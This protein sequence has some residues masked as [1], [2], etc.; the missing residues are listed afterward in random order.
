MSQPEQDH[1]FSPGEHTLSRT[2]RPIPGYTLNGDALYDRDR[3]HSAPWRLK[4]WDFYQIA[5][6]TL[7]LQLVIGHVSYA[8][9]CN[10]ALFNHLTGE[11][12]FEQGVTIPLPFRSMRMPQNA[13]ADSRL[14]FSHGGA[15]LS[16]VIKNGVRSLFARC[17]GFQ[18]TVTLTPSVPE[19]I[20]VCTPFAKQREFYFNEKINL[21][22]A[23]VSVSLDGKPYSF[24]P[25]RT[26]SLLDW[27]RGVWP[28][29]HEWYWSSVS[30][31]LAGSPFG[32][33]LGCGFG[34]TAAARG[35]ENVVYHNGRAIKLGRVEIRREAD[36][37]AP[38]HF[39]EESGRL[40]AVLTPRYDRDTVT[41]LLFVNNRCHQMF[42]TF[43]G[44]FLDSG[45][46]TIQFSGVTGFAEHAVN[47]W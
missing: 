33:N 35:T 11:R 40:S 4:E 27:G 24:D 21:L 7:C 17:G 28:F 43:E 26:F 34:D 22:R 6:D 16:F 23:D 38:W 14:E 12:I 44:R 1:K 15:E 29:S 36:V 5:D 41:K 20:S 18:A 10:I 45:G 32:F 39:E 31:L 30:T 9:N 47:H 42:G 25:E 3:I 13:R 2:G 46:R 37:F 19:S 8:G